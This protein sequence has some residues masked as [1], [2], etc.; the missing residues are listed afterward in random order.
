[1]AAI[2]VDTGTTL[3]GRIPAALVGG[4]MDANVGAISADATAADNLETMLDGTGGQSLSLGQLNIVASSNN[5]A[6]VATGAG[7]GHGIL[8]TGGATG[9]GARLLGGATSGDGMHAEAQADGDGM[10]AEGALTGAG[11]NAVGGAT[12]NSPG[13]CAQGAGTQAGIKAT[14]GGTGDGAAF[15]GGTVSGD[16]L[17]LTAGGIAGSGG[18]G[19]N[20]ANIP[21]ALVDGRMDSSV[22]AVAAAAITAAAIATGA[23]D[24]DAL[25]TDAVNAI[26]DGL[27]GRT[28]GIE[29]SY[30]LKQALRL[31][32]AASAGKLSGAATTTVTIRDVGDST[33]RIVATVD[34]DG[35]RS[36]VTLSA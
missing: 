31:I 17:Q 22:G 13:I 18:V 23:I 9:D 2:L 1:V 14:G 36:A 35:N 26:A 19:L 4:R 7:S 12:G 8:A 24:A 25:A 5:S 10:H 15:I 32:L 6:I 34:S 20:A 21:A 27:L 16:G 3:D 30:T 33:N 29:T 28:D 11:L